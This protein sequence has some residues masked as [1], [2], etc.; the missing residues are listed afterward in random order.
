MSFLAG[1][2]IGFFGV[3][4]ISEGISDKGNH[5]LNIMSRIG[6]E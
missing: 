3:F 4:T 5:F 1:W 2:D 6:F